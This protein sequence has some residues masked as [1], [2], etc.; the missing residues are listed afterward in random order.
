MLVCFQWFFLKELHPFR[1]QGSL[2][3]K[4][5][6]SSTTSQVMPKQVHYIFVALIFCKVACF[7][8]LSC[9]LHLWNSGV[10]GE[11][12]LLLMTVEGVWFA[13]ELAVTETVLLKIINT[14][15][16][17]LV[18]HSPSHPS[19]KAILCSDK[20]WEDNNR[21]NGEVC[22]CCASRTCLSS[23]HNLSSKVCF[24]SNIGSLV[25]R[26]V[27]LSVLF[28][29]LGCQGVLCLY[30]HGAKSEHFQ[31]GC[32]SWGWGRSSSSLQVIALRWP[33][34]MSNHIL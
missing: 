28:R 21:S 8:D 31:N 12:F 27:V 4:Y 10:P 5:P 25:T 33:F 14:L 20:H 13:P 7:A 9:P 15:G 11:V 19:G 1:G 34:W 29:L 32:D 2:D 18:G 22:K 30:L 17:N 24:D 23:Y 6:M 26:R 16:S 3:D